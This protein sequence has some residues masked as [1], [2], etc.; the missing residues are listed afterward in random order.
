MGLLFAHQTNCQSDIGRFGKYRGT[1]RWSSPSGTNSQPC[2]PPSSL[3]WKQNARQKLKFALFSMSEYGWAAMWFFFPSP[4]API[5]AA[6][7]QKISQ[8]APEIRDPGSSGRFP[9][10]CILPTPA[11]RRLVH[12][13]G[14]CHADR[15]TQRTSADNSSVPAINCRNIGSVD[16]VKFSALPSP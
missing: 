14:P 12:F 3:P 7:A 10:S 4:R 6:E 2:A 8:L 1:S 9:K 15:R 13:G 11:E 5:W 16:T